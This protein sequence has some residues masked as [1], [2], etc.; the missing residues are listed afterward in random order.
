MKNNNLENG[1]YK[2]KQ[3]IVYTTFE[4]GD[5]IEVRDNDILFNKAIVPLMIKEFI[6]SN[7]ILIEKIQTYQIG[8]M[9]KYKHNQFG[10]ITDI[11]TSNLNKDLYYIVTFPNKQ[12]FIKSNE[13][14]KTEVYYFISSKGK[15]C[16]SELG[17][18]MKIEKFRKAT[19]N[20]FL[21]K[22]LCTIKLLDIL[23]KIE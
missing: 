8:T 6:L 16:S 19:D 7:V 2:F 15:V 3:S 22:N 20:F 14:T 1:F 13:V 21:D 5:I 23:K 12:S 4:K 11:V 10:I 9:V 18:D 17:K